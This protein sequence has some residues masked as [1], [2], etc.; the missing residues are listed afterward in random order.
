MD[1]ASNV[2]QSWAEERERRARRVL[3]GEAQGEEWGQVREPVGGALT[4]G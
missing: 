3:A 4:D 2:E 1:A